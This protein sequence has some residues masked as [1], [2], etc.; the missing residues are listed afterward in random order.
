MSHTTLAGRFTL[1]VTLSF[2]LASCGKHPSGNGPSASSYTINCGAP[3]DVNLPDPWTD[4]LK[5]VVLCP[6]EIVKWHLRGHKLTIRFNKD[7]YPFQGPPT[8]F[9][10]DGDVN[11]LPVADLGGYTERYDYSVIVD[12]TAIH[13]PHIIVLGGGTRQP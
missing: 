12:G 7:G 11:S 8:D 5:P 2:L 10:G 13:D 6:G 4:V 9:S 3:N 1:I